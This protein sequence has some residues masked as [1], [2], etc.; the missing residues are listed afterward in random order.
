M[1]FLYHM[2]YDIPYED[3]IFVFGSNLQGIHGAGAARV[4]RIKFGAELGV[5]EGPTGQSYAIPTKYDVRKT[6]PLHDIRQKID[7][8]IKYATKMRNKTFWVTRIGCG[9]AGYTDE[10]IA[11]MF[12]N[13]PE[14]C[15]MPINW[16]E[17]L[18]NI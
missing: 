6:L 4:A 14:N 8:F 5:G 7:E 1:R 3:E 17:Y 11:P 2:D 13:S 18:E 10:Q 16:R 9:F 15:I 12:I